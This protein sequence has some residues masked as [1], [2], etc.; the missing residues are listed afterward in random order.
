MINYSVFFLSEQETLNRTPNSTT[1]VHSVGRKRKR[2]DSE[3]E[4][5]SKV[6]KKQRGNTS[7]EKTSLHELG[8]TKRRGR[9][10]RS[11]GSKEQKDGR[12][13]PAS[14]VPPPEDDAVIVLLDEDD[15]KK[16]LTKL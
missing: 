10:R 7:E 2:T 6:A 8:A 14:N 11:K 4:A 3:V 15:E 16:G 13:E 5:A 1:L 9:T 12:A